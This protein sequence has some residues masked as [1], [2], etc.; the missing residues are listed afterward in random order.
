[1]HWCN[2]RTGHTTKLTSRMQCSVSL[3]GYRLYLSGA[4]SA[5]H[6]PVFRSVYMLPSVRAGSNT[7]LLPKTT[8][9]GTFGPSSGRIRLIYVYCTRDVNVP[10]STV[11]GAEQRT[12]R[13][14]GRTSSPGRDKD[15]PP[16]CRPDR[17]WGP[18][19]SLSS[20][21]RGSAGGKAAGA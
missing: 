19:N 17:L 11:N 2:K 8:C 4:A 14:R 12:G 9:S 6:R 10:E 5:I 15:S 18:P 3:A 7:G 20:G 13:S 16:L 21:Y 1:M